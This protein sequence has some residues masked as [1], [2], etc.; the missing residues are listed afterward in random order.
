MTGT[1]P[2]PEALPQL[3]PEP[4]EPPTVTAPAAETSAAAAPAA[5]TPAAPRDRTALRAVGRWSA[6]VLLCLG[7]GAGTAYGIGSMERA[8]VPGLASED[9]G[10]WAYPR[11][12]LPALPEGSPRPF[13]QQSEAGIHHA[14]LRR[15]LLP[16][17][18]GARQDKTL[19]GGWTTQ[20]RYLSEYAEEAHPKIRLALTEYAVRHVAARGWTMPDGTSARIYLL[21]FASADEAGRFAST[22]VNALDNSIP[23]QPLKSAPT[24][25]EDVAWDSRGG[26]P[27]VSAYPFLEPGNGGATHTRQAYVHAGDT[28]ALVVHEKKGGAAAVPFH[29]TL[30][31]Q[32]QLLS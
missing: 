12:S 25:E 26:M 28:L 22:G 32:S 5:P 24:V 30:V 9:D 10:R 21:R 13:S 19:N 18:E 3:P 1:E 17:P 14:D 4:T 2:A 29:Q 7:L 15:L 27:G 20:D 8:D 16:A 31:L 6:A 11:L 23:G